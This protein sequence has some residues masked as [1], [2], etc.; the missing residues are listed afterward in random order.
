MKK[1]K[2]LPI[3]AVLFS[4]IQCRTTKL[5]QQPP[6]KI[7]KVSY[8]NWTG[9]QPGVG[10]T[11]IEIKLKEKSNIKFDSIFFQN[12][13][14]AAEIN[15]AANGMILIGY[16]NTFKRQRKDL[17]LDSNV[18]KEMKNTLPDRRNFPFQLKENEA[19]LSYKIENKI[20]YFKITDIEKIKPRFFPKVN[21]H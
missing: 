20:K 19:I 2:F 8:H 5:E 10:G 18:V 12:K 7:E 11:N 1:M 21:K 9:G 15:T 3:I 13:S 6:F 16:F 4:F 14:T 17:I